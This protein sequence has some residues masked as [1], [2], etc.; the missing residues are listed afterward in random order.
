[1]GKEYDI[2]LCGVTGFAGKLACEHLLVKNYPIKWA[3]CARNEAKATETVKAIADRLGKTALPP[4]E[5][6][7]LISDEAKLRAVVKKTKVVLTCAGPFEKYSQTLVKL[8]F[9]F[10]DELS[11]ERE[12]ALLFCARSC[13]RLR[14]LVECFYRWSLEACREWLLLLA[15]RT[16]AILGALPYTPP[17]IPAWNLSLIH[18]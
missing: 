9:D 2:V 13:V 5:V 16:A 14:E 1:M 7:C 15:R 8:N 18:I 11:E 10:H 6:A 3:C 17:K 12:D 4:I